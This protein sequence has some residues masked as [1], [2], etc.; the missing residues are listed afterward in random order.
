M[1]GREGGG[2]GRR[3]GGR[4]ERAKVGM[5]GQAREKDFS[6]EYQLQ[7]PWGG[8]GLHRELLT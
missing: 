5:M 6:Q 7:K 2:E 4:G 3:E 8:G 1:G